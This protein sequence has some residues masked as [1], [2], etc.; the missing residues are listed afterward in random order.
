MSHIR[1]DKK[2]KSLAEKSPLCPA[3][4]GMMG[5]YMEYRYGK[6]SHQVWVLRGTHTVTT[7]C[8]LVEYQRDVKIT[9]KPKHR[10]CRTC[11]K[12]KK[13]DQRFRRNETRRERR[14]ILKRCKELGV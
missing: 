1:A 4:E 2:P 14:A 10:I 6:V 7:E 5:K 8:G 3:G 13:E 9:G 12:K 11:T